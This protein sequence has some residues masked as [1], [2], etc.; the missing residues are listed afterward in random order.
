M[1]DNNLG[2]EVTDKTI[3]CEGMCFDPSRV[4]TEIFTLESAFHQS[5]LPLK[6]IRDDF[7]LQEIARTTSVIALQCRQQMTSYFYQVPNAASASRAEKRAYVESTYASANEAVGAIAGNLICPKEGLKPISFYELIGKL[8]HVEKWTY[9]VLARVEVFD[10]ERSYLEGPNLLVNVTKRGKEPV[11][12][13]LEQILVCI[14]WFVAASRVF[15]TGC[16]ECELYR[17]VNEYLEEKP[18][19]ED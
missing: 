16:T 19:C 7:Y 3:E 18:T 13:E 11:T 9:P 14:P 10:E 8:C 12:G 6:S 4:L 1:T 2:Y 5:D 15:I 17:P